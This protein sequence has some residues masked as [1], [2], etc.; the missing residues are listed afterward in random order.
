MQCA[1]KVP[2]DLLAVMEVDLQRCHSF[3]PLLI[4]TDQVS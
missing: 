4:D 3:S 1:E 2:K